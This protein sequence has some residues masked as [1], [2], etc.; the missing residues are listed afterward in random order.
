[1]VDTYTDIQNSSADTDVSPN[2]YPEF[3]RLAVILGDWEFNFMS[4]LL[5][6]SLPGTI[7]AWSYLSTYADDTPFLG[8]Y[9]DTDLPYI[10]YNTNN[11]STSIRASWISFVNSLD[12]NNYAPTTPTGYLTHWST[13]Q[14]KKQSLEFGSQS[15]TLMDDNARSA[16]YEYIR[17]R[18]ATLRL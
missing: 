8:T 15:T 2:I 6:E 16:S 11:V 13:W 5:L 9:H 18:L 7:P 3:E 4:R 17:T 1:M 10:Y 14:E 12:P